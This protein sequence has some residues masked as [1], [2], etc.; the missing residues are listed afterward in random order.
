M[1]TRK[2]LKESR[3]LDYFKRW[4]MAVFNYK[5]I[6]I[7]NAMIHSHIVGIKNTKIITDIKTANPSPIPVL[8]KL[9]MEM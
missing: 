3:K 8:E 7:A 4:I 5:T 6:S 1:Y 9:S 2:S